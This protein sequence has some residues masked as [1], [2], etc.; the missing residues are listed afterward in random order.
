MAYSNAIFYVDFDNGSDTA[1][2]ALTTCIASNPS[3]TITRINKVGHGLITGAVVDLTL[4]TAWLNGAWKITVVDADNFDLDTA[5]WQATADANGTVTPRGGSCWADA[6]K[7]LTTGATAARTGT[8]DT[9]RVAKS[10]APVSLGTTAKWT[11]VAGTGLPTAKSISSSTNATPIVM[12]V[13]AHGYSTGD[14]VRIASHTLNVAANGFWQITVLTANT[15]SLQ[16]GNGNNSIGSGTGGATG[17]VQLVNSR[18]VVLTTAQ[19]FA[20]PDGDGTTWT[21]NTSNALYTPTVARV[22]T[23]AKVGDACA[24][25]TTNATNAA[26]AN[27]KLA[28]YPL[29]ATLDLSAYNRLTFWYKFPATTVQASDVL[30]V[31]LCSDTTGDVPV[32]SFIIPNYPSAA[33][34]W[35]PLNIAKSGGGTLGASI[36][37]IA[38][39][40]GT[41]SAAVNKIHRFDGFAALATDGLSLQAL[42]SKNSS[43]QGGIESWYPIQGIYGK[44]LILDNASGTTLS[45][46]GQAYTGT[47]ETVTTY[48]RDTT[49]LTV[50]G[51]DTTIHQNMLNAANFLG[52][53]DSSIDTTV[54]NVSTANQTGET[55]LDNLIGTTYIL[56]ES[57]RTTPA[58]TMKYLNGVRG[59]AG[60]YSTTSGRMVVEAMR[61]VANTSY[62]IYLN[63]SF[64][65]T[66]NFDDLTGTGTT[67]LYVLN[68]FSNTFT[69]RS[70][71]GGATG[72]INVSGGGG[73]T[74]G[75]AT[76]LLVGS[77]TGAGIIVSGA[78]NLEF[79]N[80]TTYGN[81][82]G[83]SLAEFFN[84]Y[85]KNLTV[86][87]TTEFTLTSN[88]NTYFRSHNHDATADNHWIFASEAGSTINT[89][90]SPVNTAGGL[91]WKM[92]PAST[93]L[94]DQPLVL[95]IAKAAVQAN[96]LVTVSAWFYK[97]HATGVVGQL[98]VEG[99]SRIAGVASNVTATMSNTANTWEQLTLTFTPTEAGV[100]QVEAWAY[101]VS[102]LDSVYVDDVT[103]TQAP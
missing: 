55:F 14:I 92:S 37:S 59:I 51:G 26:P 10:P 95:P 90:T 44:F 97:T 35:S 29:P 85:G 43:E 30:R 77:A 81:G 16:D 40:T 48:F 57:A 24:S 34:R 42:V 91:S 33:T 56:Y 32:D 39:Y 74:F 86:N 71:S 93:R 73:H 63:G 54:N 69:G 6:W 25:I 66:I 17:T 21:A 7:T 68:S 45:S 75:S 9:V 15:F 99:L 83:F 58:R 60:F 72:C 31:C 82:S 80:I 94:S 79:L 13:T 3:G 87:E 78:S 27:Y 76:N 100:F 47:S 52:G 1:R 41:V 64:N 101:Y 20:I 22:A 50:T 18:A 28:H 5:V 8:T 67:G 49:K 65:N 38:V 36:R 4:F 53:W 96:K 102:T 46:A 70:I 23:D 88:Q 89:V 98:V 84:C 19:H 2:T 12:T 62:G 61:A 11:Q 103:I